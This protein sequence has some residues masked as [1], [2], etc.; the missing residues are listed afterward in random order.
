MR[1]MKLSSVAV[2]ATL[3]ATSASVQAQTYY[4]SRPTF[5]AA[6]PGLAL[7]DFNEATFVAGLAVAAPLD[8]NSNNANFTPGQIKDGILFTTVGTSPNEFYIDNTYGLPS[9][10]SLVATTNYASN[11]ADISFY[12]NNVNAF[13][14]DLYSG[15]YDIG[16][17]DSNNAQIGSSIVDAT[18]GAFFGFS[19]SLL[20]AHVAFNNRNTYETF[21]NVEFGKVG[22]VNSTVPEP[23]S[24][25]MLSGFAVTGVSF[26]LRRKRTRR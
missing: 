7:E 13:G 16:I 23:G 14:L 8:K 2:L 22:R 18:N 9:N 26:M 21:D 1:N 20:I 3:C 6:N 5:D 17:F 24:L 4:S 19:S 10:T 25:A 12:N 15:I 11:S